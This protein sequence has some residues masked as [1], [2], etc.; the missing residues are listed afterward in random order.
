MVLPVARAASIR[1]CNADGEWTTSVCRGAVDV[2]HVFVVVVVVV[3]F[4]VVAF[5]FFF[6]V[7]V[8]VFFFF[9]VGLDAACFD[10]GFAGFD[11]GFFD[12]FFFAGMAGRSR[13]NR[14]ASKH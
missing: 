9:V 3:V 1:A 10:D 13:K 8:V 5:A 4:V 7:V 11:D 12:G 14:C 6:F 2:D